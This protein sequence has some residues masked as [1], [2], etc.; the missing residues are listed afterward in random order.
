MTATVHPFK[1]FI[2]I[3]LIVLLFIGLPVVL[4]AVGLVMGLVLQIGITLKVIEL[5]GKRHNADT[6]SK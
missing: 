1:R 2:G 3:T 4:A 5:L 6:K